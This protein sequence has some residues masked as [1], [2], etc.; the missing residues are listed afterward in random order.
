MLI[1][2][3]VNPMQSERTEQRFTL[4]CKEQINTLL[5]VM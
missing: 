3:T 5:E 2:R 4:M 1:S